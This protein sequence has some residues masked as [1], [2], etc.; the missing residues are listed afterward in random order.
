V[1]GAARLSLAGLVLVIAAVI[2]IWPRDPDPPAEPP[3]PDV[4]A[5]RAEAALRPCPSAADRA[6]G[7]RSLAGVEVECLADGSEVDL[8]A[9][10]AG[11]PV[12]VNVWA[13][14]CPP[15]REELPLL[16]SYAAEPGA[17]PVVALAVK[18]SQVDALES[19]ESLGVRLPTVLDV[20][21]AASRALELPAGLPASY[22]VTP[23]GTVRLVENPRLF[24]SVD[25]IRRAVERP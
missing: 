7:P 10:L 17:V 5:V 18:S 3:A 13:T 12:L 20:D 6:P 23:D 4:D 15:C 24:R 19:L 1:T 16:A 8:A 14:W 11:A 21:G 22:L 25:E 2:A 9:V